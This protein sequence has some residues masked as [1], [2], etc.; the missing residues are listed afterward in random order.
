MKIYR[1]IS[2]GNIEENV[3]QLMVVFKCENDVKLLEENIK[4]EEYFNTRF[5]TVIEKELRICILI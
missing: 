4:N 2:T 3:S 1:Q 5:N